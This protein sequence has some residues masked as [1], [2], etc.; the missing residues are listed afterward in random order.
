MKKVLLGTLAVLTLAACSK[1]EVIQQ[2]PN[3]EITF[4]VVTNKAVSRAFD[5][6]CNNATPKEMKVSALY[7]DGT[8]PITW[9]TYFTNET[10][11]KVD[12][13]DAAEKDY[14]IPTGSGLRYWPDLGKADDG[15]KM[16]F[17]AMVNADPDW[18][19]TTGMTADF[20]VPSTVSDQKDVL[21]AVQEVD[22]KPDG[23]AQSINFRHALSQIEFMAQNQNKNIYVEI[24]GVQVM[25]VWD[26]GTIKFSASTAGNVGAHATTTG[27][28]YPENQLCTWTGLANS[29]ATETKAA[30]NF[31][32]KF[33]AIKLSQKKVTK[34]TTGESPSITYGEDQAPA[35][36]LT[37][38]NDEDKE[39]SSNTMYLLPQQIAAW[40]PT[41]EDKTPG[42]GKGS[43]FL[44]KA[45][46]WNVAA[47]DGT[48]AASGDIVL[49]DNQKKVSGEGGSE[50]TVEQFIAI[51][52][53][54]IKWIAGKR[55]VYTFIFTTD[56]NGGYNPGDGEPVL[57]PITLSVTV[58]DFVDGFP[59]KDGETTIDGTV[60]MNK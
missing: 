54:S 9:K 39:Y 49:W 38:A 44:V 3:D 40:A 41:T 37:T 16:K 46:I 58:D 36:S 4:S 45:K 13:T 7:T 5:G 6:Y 14:A 18:D 26:K 23:G 34:E 55:Y 32:V 24:S 57:T 35:S 59:Y 33:G 11:K 31:G 53:P 52:I 48:R 12:N 17:F 8:A 56:G 43:Y 51:P 20:I 29:T 28:T 27:A 10:Y 21:Y 30:Q 25:N 42:P 50:T 22:V 47:G 2:N 60:N 1:D 15:I 19:G